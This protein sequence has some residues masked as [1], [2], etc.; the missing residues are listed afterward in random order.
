[1]AK[2][3]TI[4]FRG[5]I[6]TYTGYGT[7]LCSL[8]AECANYLDVA[9]WG[10][11]VSMGLPRNVTAIL[12]KPI[13]N[14]IEIFVDFVTPFNA[15][16]KFK[17]VY[18]VLYSMVE[19]TGFT[20]NVDKELISEY[21]RTITT[22]HVAREVFEKAGCQ[23]V[24]VVPLGIEPNFWKYKPRKLGNKIRF[25][26]TGYM[27]KRKGVDLAVKAYR[28]IRKRYD[29]SLDIWNVNNV[30][31]PKEWLDIP[32]LRII[33]KP[34]LKQ[35]LRDFYYNHD[36]MLAVSRGEGFNMPPVEFLSTGGSVVAT[37]WAGHGMWMSENFA[38]PVKYRMIEV[39]AI[40]D[41]FPTTMKFIDENW[42]VKGNMWAEP[43]IEDIV[44]RMADICEDRK[45]LKEKMENTYIIRREF[46]I[47]KVTKH[48][49]N[50]IL[51]K[52]VEK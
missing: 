40:S 35:G 27:N 1:M 30:H 37:D 48:F 38:Y 29:C 20:K 23:N 19:Q 34:V 39:D 44:D 14:E 6:S 4:L 52:R 12:E 41:I 22:N 49:L 21:H 31:M 32:D 11:D 33:E 25:C 36:V 7:A 45:K 5:G 28:E 47:K 2:T 50:E 18:S 16:G 42:L 15:Y 46:N 43:V 24:S 51:P 3:A 10:I 8:V 17:N 26:T 13:P 9:L